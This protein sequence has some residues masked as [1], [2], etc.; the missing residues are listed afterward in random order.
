MAIPAAGMEQKS[1][2][3]FGG[4]LS[5]RTVRSTGTMGGAPTSVTLDF[6][7]GRVTGS[8]KQPAPMGGD[9]TVDAEIVPG[10]RV[11]EMNPWLL[12]VSDLAEG[13]TFTFPV[14][15]TRSGSVANVTAKVGAPQ[16]ITVA[17]GEFDVFPVELAGEQPQTVFLRVG[18]PH[19]MVKLAVP[20]Q[21]VTFELQS[22][23]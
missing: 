2:L 6:A 20:G 15:S 5:V 16:K 22:I 10:T 4:D 19:V 14:Y 3:A 8:A 13:K 17:A 11:A 12:A 18:A 9:R 1:E 23:Q 21:P 7:P